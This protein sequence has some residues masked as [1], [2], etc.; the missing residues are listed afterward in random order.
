MDFFEVCWINNEIH[1]SKDLKTEVIQKYLDFTGCEA[2][3]LFRE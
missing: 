1:I 3:G 2:M